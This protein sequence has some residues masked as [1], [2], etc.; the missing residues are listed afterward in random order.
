MGEREREREW[1]IRH[2]PRAPLIPCRRRCCRYSHT[3][4][5]TI[6]TLL[7]AVSQLITHIITHQLCMRY[8]LYNNFRLQWLKWL[9]IE[10]YCLYSAH[11]HTHTNIFSLSLSP[12]LARSLSAHTMLN[13]VMYSLI[14]Y[15]VAPFVSPSK[16]KAQKS[17]RMAGVRILVSIRLHTYTS[18]SSIETPN[19]KC[20]C[21]SVCLWKCEIKY[22]DRR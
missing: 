20:V 12:L 13:I 6:L 15:F 21:V 7:R 1:G 2:F 8:L 11:A 14:N 22:F 18:S 17:A 16:T 10:W 19:P 4:N 5:S 3:H 9:S